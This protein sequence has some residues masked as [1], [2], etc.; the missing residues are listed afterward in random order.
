MRLFGG[1]SQLAKNS[2]EKIPQL[3]DCPRPKRKI[4]LSDIGKLQVGACQP[5]H[6]DHEARL[7][8]GRRAF[9][10]LSWSWSRPDIDPRTGLRI[11][12]GGQALDAV[13]AVDAPLGFPDNGH[14]AVGVGFGHESME[15]RSTLSGLLGAGG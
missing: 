2:L 11:E 1:N 6:S 3:E 5:F 4:A 7:P 13:F 14:F 10:A 8:I 12:C 15:Y 9:F